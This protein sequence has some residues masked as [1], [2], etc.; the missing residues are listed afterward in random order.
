MFEGLNDPQT[1]SALL[2]FLNGAVNASQP[3]RVPMGF[4]AALGMMGQGALQGKHDFAQ[5]QLMDQFRQQ[6][7]TQLQQQNQ[8]RP[9]A[10]QFLQSMG[11]SPGAMPSPQ[12]PTPSGAPTPP[13]AGQGMA[14]PKQYPFGFSPEQWGLAS[15]AD[16]EA[17]MRSVLTAQGPH[18][19]EIGPNGTAY[20]PFSIKPGQSVGDPR[21]KS[22]EALAQEAPQVRQVIQGNDQVTEQFD[23]VKRTWSEIARGPRQLPPQPSAPMSPEAFA[24]QEKLVKERSEASLAAQ[25]GDANTLEQ[26]AQ[27]IAKY[28]MAPL[29]GF[30]IAKPAGQA[31]MSRVTQ[32]NPQYNAQNFTKSQQAYKDFGSGKKGDLTRSFNVS[33]SHLGTLDK[34]T[35]ALGNGDTQ[36]LNQARNSFKEQF[37]SDAPTNFNAAKAIVGD[38]I[39]KAIVGSGGAL[40]D[41]ENAANQISSA[42]TPAQLKGVIRTYKE[43]MAGQLKGLKQQYSSSTMRDD[44]DTLLSPEAKAELDGTISAAAPTTVK[45]TVIAPPPSQAVQMLKMNPSLGAQFDAKYGPG[46]AKKALGR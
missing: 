5:Q 14:M 8:Q 3:T 24:Q 10:E 13:V 39:I 27:N 2:G 30:A 34:L 29:S 1:Q 16:P 6:Q 33:I 20:D 37:G 23:P 41:R 11:T 32:I 25:M 28:Q 44:F 19:M 22:P 26:T 31:I 46:S 7:I 45:Q 40:A 38:E 43:L 21:L 9:A 15:K 4:G 18:R 36:L 35:D 17:L 12:G 42:K